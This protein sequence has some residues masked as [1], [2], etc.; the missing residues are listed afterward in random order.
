MTRYPQHETDEEWLKINKMIGIMHNFFLVTSSTC[1]NDAKHILDY[2][3][4]I[5]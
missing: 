4:F 5:F 2:H 3:L 1:H